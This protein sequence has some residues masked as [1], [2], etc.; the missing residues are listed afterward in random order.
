MQWIFDETAKV[1]LPTFS[2]DEKKALRKESENIVYSYVRIYVSKESNILII[3]FTNDTDSNDIFEYP[4]NDPLIF[5]IYQLF[6]NKLLKFNFACKKH[7]YSPSKKYD[8]YYF[9][10][11]TICKKYFN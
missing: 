2:E 8:I 11:H 9:D 1:Y 10:L 4:I 5:V 6:L 3:N 7:T